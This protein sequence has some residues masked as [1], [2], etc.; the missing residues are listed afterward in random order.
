MNFRL[1]SHRHKLYTNSPF[2]PSNQRTWSEWTL[3]P[4]GQI[5]EIIF[6]G[7]VGYDPEPVGCQYH[8]KRNF[9]IEPFTGFFD[10]Q[11][12]KIYL[13]DIVKLQCFNLDYEIVWHVDRFGMKPLY[14]TIDSD[15][16]TPHHI[17]GQKDFSVDWLVVNTKHNVEYCD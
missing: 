10:C 17:R 9:S 12:K 11:N 3:T 15:N 2:W 7:T 1:F 6:D 16:T 8:D 13:G 14:Q 5:L 4:D